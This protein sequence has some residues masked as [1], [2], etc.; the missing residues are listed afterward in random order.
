MQAC[1]KDTNAS[2]TV[3]S[4]TGTGQDGDLQ[5]GVAWPSPRFADNGNGTVTDRLTNLIW[6]KNANC[7]GARNWEQALA[8]ANGLNTGECGLSD[9]STAGQWRLPNVR[10]QQSPINY[11]RF[12]L[13]LPSGHPF[14]GMQTSNYWSSAT[15]A[16]NTSYA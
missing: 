7:Y 11:G 10:E 16:G 2:G 5:K 14:S 8:D 6:L 13:A 1:R 12:N 9:G 4:C 15:Y 3:I